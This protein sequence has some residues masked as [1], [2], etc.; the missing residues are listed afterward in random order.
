GGG[1]RRTSG[2]SRL[3]ATDRFGG[4]QLA[5]VLSA[6]LE[7]PGESAR[8]TNLFH[9]YPAALR[10][11]AAR[12]LLAAFP[13]RSVLDPFCGGGTVLVEARAAGG[14]AAGGGA[15]PRAGRGAPA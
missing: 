9:T 1:R 15:S 10:A 11:D 8:Y 2:A 4:A 6:A 12:D 14:P 7:Q 5:R 3:V 13:S